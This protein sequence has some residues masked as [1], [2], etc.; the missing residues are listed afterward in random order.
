MYI[1]EGNLVFLNIAFATE[2]EG[3]ILIIL[4]LTD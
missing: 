1:S 2:N 4:L 3:V